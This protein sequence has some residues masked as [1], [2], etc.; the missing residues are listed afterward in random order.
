MPKIGL[1]T[2]WATPPTSAPSAESRPP[3]PPHA[4]RRTTPVVGPA[5][6][7]RAE[8]REQLTAPQGR[9]QPDELS[10]VAGDDDHLFFVHLLA[11]AQMRGGGPYPP[12]C[13]V[14]A[15]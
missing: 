11:T 8:R 3:P 5:P 14:P 6:D 15:P 4:R 1:R 2:W 9:L 10:D 7:H 12:A 13:P